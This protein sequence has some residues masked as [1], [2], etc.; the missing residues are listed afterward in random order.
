MGPTYPRILERDAMAI[1]TTTKLSGWSTS[2]V[3]LNGADA[4]R[5]R[6]DGVE[7]SDYGAA[8]IFANTP[9]ITAGQVSGVGVHMTEPHPGTDEYTPY[10][11][12]AHLVAS[13]PDVDCIVFCGENGGTL[14]NGAS[15]NLLQNSKILASGHRHVSF[16]SVVL[17]PEMTADRA[18]GFGIGVVAP[19]SGASSA[20]AAVGRISVRRLM[21]WEPAV[22]DSRKLG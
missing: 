21:R 7:Y 15:G 12:S 18:V 17:L 10:A 2:F 5:M 11:I 1:D 16:D 8:Y 14:S 4:L 20:D 6:N 3:D 13:D 19:A 9:A 22:I